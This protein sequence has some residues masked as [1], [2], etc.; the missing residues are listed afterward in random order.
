MQ[1]LGFAS[2]SFPR[3]YCDSC[4]KAKEREYQAKKSSER[5][6]KAL[7][8][9]ITRRE[10]AV[11]LKLQ[12]TL[13]EPLQD[14]INGHHDASAYKWALLHGDTGVG[15]TTLL[16]KFAL[17]FATHHHEHLPSMMYVTEPE[18]MADLKR[19]ERTY[20]HYAD[21]G[22]LLVD[23]LGLSAGTEYEFRQWSS[24]INDR[25]RHGRITVM[26][27]NVSP[28]ALKEHPMFGARTMRRINEMAGEEGVIH[29][30]GAP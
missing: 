2:Y 18:I 12:V 10:L 20:K 15:K 14:I 17:N 3:P 6:R 23:E 9:V 30:Q 11:L 7:C 25:Y 4:S 1:V 24:I 28:E 22:L 26:A 19:F 29:M 21:V 5:I 13:P 8:G 16:H 27:S